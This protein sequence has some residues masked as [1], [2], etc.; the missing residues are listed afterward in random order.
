MVTELSDGPAAP[1]AAVDLVA[2]D[3]PAAG[4]GRRLSEA[5]VATVVLL[6]PWDG[7]SLPT[8][9]LVQGVGASGYQVTGMLP[10]DEADTPTALIAGRVDAGGPMLH[11]YLRWDGDAAPVD[12]P[13]VLRLVNEHHVE[14]FVWRVLDQRVRELDERARDLESRRAEAEKAGAEATAENERLTAENERLIA[15]NA[16]ALKRLSDATASLAQAHAERDAVQARMSR[17][18][19]SS[20]YRLARRLAAGKQAMARLVGAG[21]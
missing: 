4:L 17:I 9:E 3:D 2:A 8:G 19:G 21:R 5:G 6:L 16:T 20:S 14:G 13:A 10:L 15:D 7:G 11:P 18:E 12:P 1:A